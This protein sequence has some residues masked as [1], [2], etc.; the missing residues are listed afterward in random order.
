[1]DWTVI[2]ETITSLISSISEVSVIIGV[3][4]DLV[5]LVM[6]IFG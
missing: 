1:M 2:G 6:S 4:I 3:I 5:V